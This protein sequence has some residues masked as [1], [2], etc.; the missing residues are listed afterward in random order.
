MPSYKAAVENIVDVQEGDYFERVFNLVTLDVTG[1]SGKAQ[2]REDEG[3]P[4]LLE[5]STAN[6]T[7][8]CSGTQITIKCDAD[9]F[10][11]TK[12]IY[13]YD[14]QIYT[15]AQ[16]VSTIIKGSFEVGNNGGQITI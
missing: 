8:I 11:L 10:T 13:Y 4:V 7:M 14:L 12:G 9:K 2:V 5:F 16:D 3:K 1:K 6:A 15:T